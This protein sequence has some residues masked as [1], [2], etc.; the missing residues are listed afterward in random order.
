MGCCFSSNPLSLPNSV[1]N[2]SPFPPLAQENSKITI[3]SEQ[4]IHQSEGRLEATYGLEDI[5]GS[6]AYGRVYSATHLVTGAK[7]AVKVLERD[8]LPESQVNQML[9]E[10][11]MLKS[12]VRT[13]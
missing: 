10:V 7:R 12:L 9:S 1:S 8:K 13:S 4:F 5:L 3:K 6:G 2:P 11:Y